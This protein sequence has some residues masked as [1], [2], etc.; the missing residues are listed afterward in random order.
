MSGCLI[1]QRPD[2]CS[3]TSLESIRTST[4]A[5]GSRSSAACRPGD[6]AA[7]L[8]DVVGRPADGRRPLGEHPPGLGVAH[9]RAVAGRARVAPRPAVRLDDEPTAHR[10]GLGRAH[11]DPAAVLAADHLV[12]VGVAHRGQLVA[13]QLEPAALARRAPG[14]SRRRCSRSACG[15]GRRAPA[16]AREISAD[17]LGARRLVPRGRVG[18]VGQ[19]VVPEL[20]GP[21]AVGLR[22]RPAPPARPPAPP[23]RP[24]GAP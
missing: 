6:Q 19:G 18:D 5:V 10:P 1:F 16:A 8:G 21:L 9:E 4:S 14:A 11:Q 22:L 7:V 17:H 20:L 15:S 13:V 2:I 12:R 24:P 3:T 23:R